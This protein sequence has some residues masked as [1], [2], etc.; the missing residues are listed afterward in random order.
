MDLLKMTDVS[1]YGITDVAHVDRI[2]AYLQD[3]AIRQK[4]YVTEADYL[5]LKKQYDRLKVQNPPYILPKKMDHWKPVDVMFFMLHDRNKEVAHKFVK[6]LAMNKV[7]GA[8]LLKRCRDATF[9]SV[10]LFFLLVQRKSF[11]SRFTG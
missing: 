6:P 11:I 9:V 1:G 10:P 7:D 5:D 2:E 4:K 8:D 3:L